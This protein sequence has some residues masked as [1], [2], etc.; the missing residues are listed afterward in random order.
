MICLCAQKH[1]QM[2]PKLSTNVVRQPAAALPRAQLGVPAKT[3]KRV[4]ACSGQT[5]Q[6]GQQL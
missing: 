6:N 4:F 3:S 2:W 1:S 5:R